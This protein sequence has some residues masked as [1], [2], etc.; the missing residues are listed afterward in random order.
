MNT[1]R[2]ASPIVEAEA[3]ASRVLEAER[4]ARAAVAQCEVEAARRVSAANAR[5]QALRERTEARMARLSM[6]MNVQAQERLHQIR[7]ERELLAGETGADAATLA[8]LDSAVEKLVSEIA[9]VDSD[10]GKG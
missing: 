1:P 5:A 4:A 9:G 10:S 6:R 2:S 8:R 3:A 7:T